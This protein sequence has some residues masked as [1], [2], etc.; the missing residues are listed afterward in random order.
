VAVTHLPHHTLFLCRLYD[1]RLSAGFDREVYIANLLGSNPKACPHFP[2]VFGRFIVENGSEEH[3]D[4][5]WPPPSELMQA[6]AELKRFRKEGAIHCM[7]MEYINENSL[8][9]KITENGFNPEKSRHLLLQIAFALNHALKIGVTH[10]DLKPDNIFLQ[11][12]DQETVV[13]LRCGKRTL[14]IPQS[15]RIKVADFGCSRIEQEPGPLFHKG[16]ITTPENTPPD[17]LLLGN[18]A[19]AGRKQDAYGFALIML[20]FHAC[21]P[22]FLHDITVPDDFVSEMVR[23]FEGKTEANDKFSKIRDIMQNNHTIRRRLIRSLYRIMV[24]AGV[25]K[26]LHQDSKLRESPIW[27]FLVEFITSSRFQ[28]H[29]MKY[30][31]KNGTETEF[32]RKRLGPNGTLLLLHLMHMDPLQRGDLRDVLQSDFLYENLDKTDGH[33]HSGAE[34]Y[35]VF[36]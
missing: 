35:T 29:K 30:N 2:E 8:S 34:V 23:F 4:L 10:Y 1:P 31:L 12:L 22:F 20:D 3:P 9:E 32:L 36:E 33:D 6:I 19:E 21:T 27:K 7:H 14:K 25:P 13:F 16:C 24:L 28:T 17:C 15:L 18:Q 11:R 5:C 26:R